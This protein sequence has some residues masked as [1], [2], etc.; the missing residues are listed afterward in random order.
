VL[1]GSPDVAS[2]GVI[3]GCL[4]SDVKA[5]EKLKK[6]CTTV[7]EFLELAGGLANA[8]LIAAAAKAAL[9]G[10]F[11][12]VTETMKKVPCGYDTRNEMQFKF[13]GGDKKVTTK[14]VNPSETLLKFLLATRMP[15]FFSETKKVEI[16]KKVIEI[17]QNTEDEIKSFAGKLLD[18]IEVEAEFESDS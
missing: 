6:E 4:D 18:A 7:D 2:L 16:N 15:E 8:K 14:K 1:E 9:G 12:E 5:L 17:K 13:V 10:T 11:D 3:M